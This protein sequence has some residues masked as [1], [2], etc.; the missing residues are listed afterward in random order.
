M[1]NNISIPPFTV[2]QLNNQVK[3]SLY[4]QYKNIDVIG[5][6]NNL[7]KYSSGHVYF[8]LK[9]KSSEISCVM[10]NSY[11]EQLNINLKD[12]DKV[13]LSGDVTIW[14]IKKTIRF[15]RII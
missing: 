10:F 3:A 12:G 14:K 7:K 4:Q 1:N 2:T 9:D 13:V 8:I 15:R 11:Y 5:E 6:I